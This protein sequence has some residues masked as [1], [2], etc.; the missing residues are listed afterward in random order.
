MALK[1]LTTERLRSVVTS[2]DRMSF[3]LFVAFAIHM[4]IFGII[5]T[6]PDYQSAKMSTLDITLVTS[7][8]D[9]TNKNADYFAQ[10]NQLGAGNTNDKT[11]VHKRSSIASELNNPGTSPKEQFASSTDK[12]QQGKDN[13]LTQKNSNL[14]VSKS[15]EQ[16]KPTA[17][18]NVDNTEIM[19]RKKDLTQLQQEIEQLH[20]I[21]TSKKRSYKILVASTRKHKD[22]AYLAIWRQRV[23]R[24]GQRYYPR[25][26]LKKNIK[27][28]V[29]LDVVI[30][31]RGKIQDIKLLDSSG[32]R[33]LD[34][35]AEKIVRLAAPYPR[36]PA[37]VMEDKKVLHI[38]YRYQFK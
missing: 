20:T 25:K 23:K 2:S 28:S 26:A 21:Y 15:V 18:A 11:D 17:E 5:F 34:K 38:V 30:N 3:T 24:I 29:L 27:G 9:K 35:S 1:R 37:E 19:L 7:A 32:H 33:L 31:Q 36:V 12:Q 13:V 16:N 10:A 4:L 14:E 22:A 6:R 8:T